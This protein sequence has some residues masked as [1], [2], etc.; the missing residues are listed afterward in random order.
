MILSIIISY[1][2]EKMW[3]KKK[4]VKELVKANQSTNETGIDE[5]HE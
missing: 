2:I 5:E 3:N 4:D 1:L